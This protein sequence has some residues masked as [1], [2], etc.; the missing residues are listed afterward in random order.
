MIELG[1]VGVFR[2]II[3]II[4]TYY[5]VRFLLRW[6]VKIKLADIKKRQQNSVSEEEANFKRNEKGKVHIKQ[7]K[8]SVRESTGGDYIDYEEVD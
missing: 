7:T 4:L 2:T 5:V 6:W 3:I 8:S 1:Y